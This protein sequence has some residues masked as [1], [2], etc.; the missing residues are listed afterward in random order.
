M[1]IRRVALCFPVV[2]TVAVVAVIQE[3]PDLDEEK[4]Q[5]LTT[6]GRERPRDFF[7]LF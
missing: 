7:I 1:R 3:I 5:D 2:F 4:Q 6:Q